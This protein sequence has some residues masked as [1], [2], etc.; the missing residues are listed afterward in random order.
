MQNN[1]LQK[2]LEILLVDDDNSILTSHKRI[3]E[4]RLNGKEYHIDTALNGAV[5]LD[6]VKEK[7]WYDVIFTD[8]QM[9]LKNGVEFYKSLK[10]VNKRQ[11]ERVFMF[12][13]NETD[14]LKNE[15]NASLGP[16]DHKPL[17]IFN[18]MEFFQKA[19]EIIEAYLR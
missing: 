1:Q 5:A 19:K 13:G 8:Y 16:E 14:A 6:K 9:P 10:E 7:G 15:V 17:A 18:K 11:Q 2:P 3:L 12:S 4:I